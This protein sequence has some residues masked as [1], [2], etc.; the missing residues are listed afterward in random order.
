MLKEFRAFIM[1]GNVM[2]LAVGVIIGGAFGKIVASLV[3]DILMPLIGLLIGGID[4][5]SL[6]FT[7]GSA[8]VAYGLFINN[9]IDFLI[10]ALV[11]F[12]MVKALNNLQKKPAATPAAPATKE[13]P[14]CFSTIAIK[15]TRCPNCTSELK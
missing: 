10:I 11:I 3:N 5:S 9:I 15:A 12:L 13:C 4:F 8:T 6:S 1:R 14:R 2:D 7:L